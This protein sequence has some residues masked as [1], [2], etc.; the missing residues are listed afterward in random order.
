MSMCCWHFTGDKINLDGI[1]GYLLEIVILAAIPA[2]KKKIGK[3]LTQ[4]YILVVK[5]L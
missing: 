3:T 1:M 4:R 5:T 2:N